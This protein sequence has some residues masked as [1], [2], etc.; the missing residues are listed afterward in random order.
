MTSYINLLIYANFSDQLCHRKCV[1]TNVKLGSGFN[2]AVECT[3]GSREVVGS[4]PADAG[5]FSLSILSNESLNIS[6]VQHY[7]L[8]NKK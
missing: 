5:L 6:F 2:T 4:I 7:C 1:L 3:P 8:S